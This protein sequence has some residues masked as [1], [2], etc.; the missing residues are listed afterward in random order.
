MFVLQCIFYVAVIL[1]CIVWLCQQGSVFIFKA[2]CEKYDLDND[3]LK[4]QAVRVTQNPSTK[5]WDLDIGKGLLGGDISYRLAA[6]YDD[7]KT[8]KQQAEN[9]LKLVRPVQIIEANMG[10]GPTPDKFEMIVR[11]I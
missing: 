6:H 11:C 5:K 9:W 2:I 10:L 4:L 8:A 1:V 3:N 7:E